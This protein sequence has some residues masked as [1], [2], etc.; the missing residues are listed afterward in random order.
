MAQDI[1]SSTGTDLIFLILFFM[2]CQI[3][4]TLSFCLTQSRGKNFLVKKMVVFHGDSDGHSYSRKR[5]DTLR[6]TQ[7]TSWNSWMKSLSIGGRA[8]ESN[9][10][11]VSS[12]SPL[13]PPPHKLHLIALDVACQ[14][15]DQIAS[16]F[17]WTTV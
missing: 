2:D 4:L 13:P 5:G 17:C 14:V 11:C 10:V 8:R 15:I 9:T 7:E 3:I 16:G 6:V 12:F 1:C